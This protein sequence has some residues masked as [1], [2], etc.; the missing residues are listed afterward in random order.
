ML[1]VLKKLPLA[2]KN[3]WDGDRKEEG[4]ASIRERSRVQAS[5]SAIC[6][7]EMVTPLQ[8]QA[9]SEQRC[10]RMV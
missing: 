5:L 9:A 3:V 7:G 2:E 1:D 10:F 4:K 6:H 8:D